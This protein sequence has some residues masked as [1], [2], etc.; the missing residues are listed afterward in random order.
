[1]VGFLGEDPHSRKIKDLQEEIR[2]SPRAKALIA[3]RDQRAVQ[4]KYVYASWRGAHWSLAMLAEIGYPAG[5]ATLLPM[6]DQVLDYWLNDS[7]YMEFES[8]SAVPKHRAPKACLLSRGAIGGA[9]RS[10][11]T[12]FIRSPGWGSRT[13][14][15]TR[16]LSA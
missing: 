9:R 10:R 11:V 2:K 3:G 12:R 7:F 5:D 16:W 14:R 15:A 6:R 8:K 1:M 4:E 13:R